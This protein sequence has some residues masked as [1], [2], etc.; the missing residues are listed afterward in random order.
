LAP[1]RN[2]K[3]RA[4]RMWCVAWL[5]LAVFLTGCA[6]S[7]TRLE[8]DAGPVSWRVT[9]VGVVK[10]GN[11]DV[12]AAKLVIK[13]MR[14]T[15]I[16]FTRYERTVS[17]LKLVR[18]A[19]AVSTGRWVVR[20]NAEW[21]LNLSHSIVCPPFPGGCGS[22]LTTSAPEFHITLSGTTSEGQPVNVA[23]TVSLPPTQLR[24]RGQ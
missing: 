17:D 15:T 11:D 10:R 9:D 21:T 12:Y 1:A 18:A 19:P 8:G 2:S 24:M 3:F 22:P 23:I 13:E 7:T 16:T 20:P 6:A 4:P 14:G 5:L